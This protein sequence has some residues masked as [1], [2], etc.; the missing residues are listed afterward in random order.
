MDTN[1]STTTGISKDMLANASPEFRSA[2][3]CDLRIRHPKLTETIDELMRR[4]NN[5][6]DRRMIILTGPAGVGKSVACEYIIQSLI[7]TYFQ[8]FP[9][10]TQTIP[11]TMVEAEGSRSDRFDWYELDEAILDAL[12]VPL[13]DATLPM[14]TRTLDGRLID[15]PMVESRSHPTSRSLRA[16]FRVA[17]DQRKPSVVAIDEASNILAGPK[18]SDSKRQANV[19]KTIINKNKTRLI[20]TGAYDLYKLATKSGQLARRSQIVHFEPYRDHSLKGFAEAL[21]TFQDHLPFSEPFPLT[22]YSAEL[23]EQSLGCIGLLK[24]ILDA[25]VNVAISEAKKTITIGMLRR[26]Y[27]RRLQLKILIDEILEGYRLIEG[28][29]YSNLPAFLDSNPSMKARGKKNRPGVRS[30]GRD[31]A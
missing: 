13:I 18:A 25:T 19:L 14:V 10:D 3:F 21:S 27:F 6:N 24:D 2:Y 17:L 1:S 8:N 29:E 20:L 11:A 9:D 31:V 16:R 7:K 15:V 30:P 22:S 28:R 23:F 26:N 5:G 4:I 12:H